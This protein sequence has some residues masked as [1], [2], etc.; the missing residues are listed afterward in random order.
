M[1]VNWEVISGYM[2]IYRPLYKC[3]TNPP[4]SLALA[5]LGRFDMFILRLASWSE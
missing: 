5:I 4:V 2:S 3:D 1:K